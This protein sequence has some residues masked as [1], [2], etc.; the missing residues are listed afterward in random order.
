MNREK[1]KKSKQRK[2]E[3]NKINE[4][5]KRMEKKEN[6]KARKNKASNR[7]IGKMRNNFGKSL[8]CASQ[9][10]IHSMEHSPS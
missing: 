5:Q 6:W 8:P 4:L 10:F 7:F 3:G 9:Q 2:V 1:Q